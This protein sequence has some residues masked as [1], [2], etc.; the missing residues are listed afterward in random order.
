MSEFY[1]AKRRDDNLSQ[2]FEQFFPGRKIVDVKWHNEKKDEN[3]K[4][5]ERANGYGIIKQIIKSHDP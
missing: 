3:A 4:Q 2:S 5:N 1:N